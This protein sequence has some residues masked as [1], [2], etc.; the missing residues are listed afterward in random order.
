MH[1]RLA[2]PDRVRPRSLPLRRSPLRPESRTSVRR[3]SH[4]FQGRGG[5]WSGR[6][7]GRNP[8][9]T[10][11]H[12]AP[13]PPG[14]LD[15]SPRRVIPHRGRSPLERPNW[16][17]QPS[18]GGAGEGRGGAANGGSL[19]VHYGGRLCRLLSRRDVGAAFRR[20]GVR[21]CPRTTV[22]LAAAPSGRIHPAIFPLRVTHPLAGIRSDSSTST[23]SVIAL[24]RGGLGQ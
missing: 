22:G 6:P 1:L 9:I 13:R 8:R 2:G 15:R 20:R 19:L 16:R 5:R 24:L 17:G 12:L 18:R 21:L 4:R 14:V 23:S 10:V 7:A 11:P 3:R